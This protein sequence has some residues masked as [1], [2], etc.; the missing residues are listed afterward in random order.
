MKTGA[1]ARSPIAAEKFG[2]AVNSLPPD[3]ESLVCREIRQN[4]QWAAM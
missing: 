1:R 4:Y 2:G 3:I